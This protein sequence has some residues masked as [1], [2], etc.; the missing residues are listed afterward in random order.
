ML[1]QNLYHYTNNNKKKLWP[2]TKKRRESEGG[3]R[4]RNPSPI[5]AALLLCLSSEKPKTR[6]PVFSLSAAAMASVSL[7]A[8]A[9]VVGAQAACHPCVYWVVP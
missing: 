9:M 7:T 4:V 5:F 1:R 2:K 6:A 8:A 3:G